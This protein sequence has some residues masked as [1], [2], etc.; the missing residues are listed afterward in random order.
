MNLD[1]FFSCFNHATKDSGKRNT[2]KRRIA[3]KMEAVFL[4]ETDWT[5]GRHNPEVRNLQLLPGCLNIFIL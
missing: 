2:E 4:S 5:M 1:F 3:L